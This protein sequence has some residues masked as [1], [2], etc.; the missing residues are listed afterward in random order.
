T[1]TAKVVSSVNPSVFGQPVTLSTTVT[2]NP[3][4]AG[5]PTGTVT[6]FDGVTQIGTATLNA[7]AAS[8]TISTFSVGSHSITAT[9]GGDGS[10]N[11]ST[12]A[13]ALIQVVNKANTA[14]VVVASSNPAF[15]HT[16]VTFTATVSAVPPGAGIPTGTVQFKDN[17]VNIGAPVA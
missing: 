4:G 12:T 3:P 5:T 10:F 8:I 6:F 13:T 2:A 7:G 15:V 1:T 16:T 14:T 17:G 11:G 9:Y